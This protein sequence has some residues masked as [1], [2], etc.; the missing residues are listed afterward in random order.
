MHIDFVM[1]NKISLYKISE[2]D[3]DIECQQVKK[4]SVW[5]RTRSTNEQY[6]DPKILESLS[7]T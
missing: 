6:P 7:S 1:C 2:H 3:N 4:V 5:R